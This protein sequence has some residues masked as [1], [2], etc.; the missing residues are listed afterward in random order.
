VSAAGPWR[1]ERG[2]WK[3]WSLIRRSITNA[4][5]SGL[6]EGELRSELSIVDVDVEPVLIA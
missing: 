2:I 1:L 3:G 5:V 6:K 4:Y